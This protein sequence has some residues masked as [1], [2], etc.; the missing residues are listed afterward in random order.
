MQRFLDR[1]DKAIEDFSDQEAFVN[2]SDRKRSVKTF[3]AVAN[4]V[5]EFLKR[6][7]AARSATQQ[8]WHAGAEASDLHRQVFFSW[9]AAP[10]VKHLKTELWTCRGVKP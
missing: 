7:V 9:N 1:L 4:D 10:P 5:E 3:A 6:V 8:D 2:I